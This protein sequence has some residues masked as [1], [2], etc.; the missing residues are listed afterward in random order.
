[1]ASTTFVDYSQNT[2]IVAAW[3]NPVNTCVYSPG[4]VAKVAV[5]SA[6]AWVRFAVV[7]GVVTIQQSSNIST[8]VR[9]S[10]GIFVITYNSALTGA[11]NCY[12]ITGNTAGF[13]FANAEANNSVTVNFT[14]TANTFT[15]P[16]NASVL[17]FGAN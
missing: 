5:Q 12:S 17:V 16:G 4:G 10:P 9:T 11:Q 15:D 6:A 2:P 1:M 3:L 13:T 14:N 7:A 8:V